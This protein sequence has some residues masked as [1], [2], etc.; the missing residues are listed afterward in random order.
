MGKH[1]PGPWEA[2]EK[3][4]ADPSEGTHYISCGMGALGYWRGGKQ[5]H[6]DSHWVLNGADARLIAAA[7]ELL[8]ACKLIV[9]GQTKEGYIAANAAIRK[10]EGQPAA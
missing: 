5:R 4:D 6:E 10:A 1:T 9:S 3:I 2:V 7:P 8:E